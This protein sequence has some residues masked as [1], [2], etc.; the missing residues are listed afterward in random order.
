MTSTNSMLLTKDNWKGVWLGALILSQ[1]LWSDN[2]MSTATF[3]AL[4][5]PVT[6]KQLRKLQS[7]FFS[8]IKMVTCVKP[9]QYA[10]VRL[11]YCW[12]WDWD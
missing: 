4:V 10:E 3:A 7:K 2:P 5:Q 11:R 12:D 1:K 8:L 9:S 6:D